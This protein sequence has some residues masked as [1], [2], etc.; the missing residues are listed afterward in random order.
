[1]VEI[2][3]TDSSLYRQRADILAEMLVQLLAAVP[4]A[5]TG[6]DGVI[7]IVFDIEAA[8]LEN[9][10]LAHQLLLEDSFIS[11]ASY[12]ALIRHGEQYGESFSP[13]TPST[14]TLQFEGDG[15]T[16]I[17]TGTEVGY[18]P[19]NGL[20][21]VYFITTADATVPNPG[22]PTAPTAAI[23]ATAGNLNGVYEYVVTF[24]TAAGETLP[25]PESV[26]V[27]PANQQVDL[28]NIPLGGAGTISRRIYRDKNGAGTYRRV[29]EIANNTATTY[30]DN[31]SDGTVS[32][33]AA[34]PTDDTAHQIVVA[35]QSQDTGVEGNVAIG[36]ITDL[37]NAPA[38]LT[39]VTNP[40]A[41]TGASDP[42][43]IEDFRTRLL[44]F[45]QNPQTGSAGDLKSWA[46]DISGVGSA[47]VFPNTP[48]NGS[49]TVRI[50][51]EDGTVPDA[52]VVSAVQAALNAKD[53]AN[54]TIIVSTFT[55]VPTDV[56]VD[57]TP[58]GTY[59][60]ADVSPS[61]IAAISDYINGLDVGATL[62]VAG[63][64]DSVFGLP[65]IADVTISNPV[66]NQA[67]A[68]TS[69][70]TPGVITVT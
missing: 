36:T 49:V 70:R 10:Y 22:N 7:H 64:I 29:T 27:N 67:T 24:V 48:A 12:Q 6:D 45:I 61:V 66:V 17:P 56:T 15:G 63:I 21:V 44:A 28:S 13:G 43:D 31:V 57:V 59:A 3:I 53:M 42:E 37:T 51:A 32:T 47:T 23:N 19:Q 20:D 1:V 4:D 58:S 52:S 8:Q 41:F 18:D 30:T 65:G 68:A 55:S 69:K 14:G 11:T 5:Y 50:T 40:V 60:L 25:S 9:L 38:T 35:A 62:Y 2:P 26:A 34:V 39:G 46:E 16:F 54:I 33:G